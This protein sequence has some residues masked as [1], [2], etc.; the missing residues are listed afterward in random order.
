MDDLQYRAITIRLDEMYRRHEE[1]Q[2]EFVQLSSDVHE[3]VMVLHSW[4]NGMKVLNFLGKIAEPLSY[5][6]AVCGA[7]WAFWQ[8]RGSK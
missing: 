5:I 6:L 1:M 2:A 4:K 8:T 3:L 7:I